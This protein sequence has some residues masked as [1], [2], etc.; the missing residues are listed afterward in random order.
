[1]DDI[2]TYL[3]ILEVLRKQHISQKYLA[4]KIKIKPSSLSRMLSGK[5]KVKLENLEK[6]SKVLDLPVSFFLENNSYQYEHKLSDTIE[7]NENNS[8]SREIELLKRE[9]NIIKKENQILQ[10]ENK[11]LKSKIKK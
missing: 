9:I 4:E 7:I 1:M 10:K 6:I 8:F 2:K 11:Q 5:H 3:K